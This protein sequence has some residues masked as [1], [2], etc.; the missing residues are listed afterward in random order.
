MLQPAATRPFLTNKFSKCMCQS[1]RAPLS[2][3]DCCIVC[4]CVILNAQRPVEQ[5]RDSLP[6]RDV[7]STTRS[8]TR[9]IS[10]AQ[11]RTR[12]VLAFS[13]PYF[14]RFHTLRLL[15]CHWHP[16][17][18]PRSQV[19]NHGHAPNLRIANGFGKFDL[20]MPLTENVSLV[21]RRCLATTGKFSFLNVALL[22]ALRS[23]PSHQRPAFAHALIVVFRLQTSRSR[24]PQ[25][26]TAAASH[27]L[28]WRLRALKISR[29]PNCLRQKQILCPVVSN[30]NANINGPCSRVFE[31]YTPIAVL[32]SSTLRLPRAAIPALNG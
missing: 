16:Q 2:P 8:T 11:H 26:K 14:L 22:L 7:D 3:C 29:R 6:W 27:A 24:V 9:P 18:L 21:A 4:D 31:P 10:T 17:R 5:P 20:G 19:T 12:R 32:F 28:P 25:S 30:H 13:L 23:L 15:A 1:W